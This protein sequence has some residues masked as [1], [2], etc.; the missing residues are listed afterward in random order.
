[1]GSQ[2]P[3]HDGP[4][5]LARVVSF[6]LIGALCA[7]L[8]YLVFIGAIRLGLHYMLANILSWISAVGLNFVLNRRVTFNIVGPGMLGQLCKFIAGSLAQLGLSSVG[9][10][11]LMGEG[12]VAP[13]IAWIINTSVW[14]AAM[15][16]WLN[17]VTFRRA[18]YSGR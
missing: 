1:M 3:L 7:G 17:L 12:H 14:A 13:T 10:A 11:V 5:L 15:F 18:G 2:N 4:V 9:L 16:L 8:S 6:G